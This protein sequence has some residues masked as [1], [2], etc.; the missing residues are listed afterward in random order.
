[1]TPSNMPIDMTEDVGISLPKET[2]LEVL[3]TP[4][5]ALELY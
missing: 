5:L 4:R 3:L 1:M 2:P